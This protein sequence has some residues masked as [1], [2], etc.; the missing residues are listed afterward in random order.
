MMNTWVVGCH[1]RMHHISSAL[2]RQN[3]YSSDTA[4]HILGSVM[5][6]C[7]CGHMLNVLKDCQELQYSPVP[8]IP[9]CYK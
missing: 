3:L 5:N 8:S 7:I 9:L 1:N 4:L 6:A 2:I